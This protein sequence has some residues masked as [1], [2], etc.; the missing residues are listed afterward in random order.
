MQILTKNN[1]VVSHFDDAV[2]LNFAKLENEK[3][4][5]STQSEADSLVVGGVIS[6]YYNKDYVVNR[7]YSF[8]IVNDNLTLYENITVPTSVNLDGEVQYNFDGT[9]FTEV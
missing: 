1:L 2:V 7:S 3:H 8:R 9:T 6:T 5:V 4:W